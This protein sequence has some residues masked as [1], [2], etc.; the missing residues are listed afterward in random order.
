MDIK[1]DQIANGIGENYWAGYSKYEI[2]Q[3][4][5]RFSCL[6]KIAEKYLG[7]LKEKTP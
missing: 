7:T 6:A 1:I 4:S 3:I 2:K 5:F